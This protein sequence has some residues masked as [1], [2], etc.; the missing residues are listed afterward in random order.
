[1][2]QRSDKIRTNLVMRTR[3]TQRFSYPFREIEWFFCLL[4][5]LEQYFIY[6]AI[7][8]TKAHYQAICS[9]TLQFFFAW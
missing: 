7:E 3:N 2:Y 6:D 8:A 9:W 5:S 4:A 1:M